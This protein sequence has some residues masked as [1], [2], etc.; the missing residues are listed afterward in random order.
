MGKRA[1][2]S[3]SIPFGM[4]FSI[5][6]IVVFIV[7]AF[8]AVNHFLSIGDCSNVGQFYADLQ[9]QVDN[10]WTSQSSNASFKIDLP[11]GVEKICFYNQS[12]AVS[13]SA[14]DDYNLIEEKIPGHNIFLIPP[15]KSCNMP[16][17]EILHLDLEYITRDRNPYCVDV[18]RDLQIKK[19][20]Y[21]KFVKIE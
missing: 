11:S 6:L 1:Q 9:K 13:E 20:F 19:D 3:M 16:S 12:K 10:I 14:K 7:I 5:L 21:D 17:K 4:I 18:S 2:E 8:I 15:G